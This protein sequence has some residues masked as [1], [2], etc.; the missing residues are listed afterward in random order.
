M[1]KYYTNDGQV[2]FETGEDEPMNKE[3]KVQELNQKIDKLKEELEK[4]QE[5]TY[6]VSYPKD[7]E[8]VYFINPYSN[9]IQHWSFNNWN[10]SIKQLYKLGMLFDT[11]KEAEQFLKEQTLI[12]KIKCWV[13]EQQGDWKPD[14][15]NTN[16]RKYCVDIDRFNKEIIY[17]WHR[18][19]DKLPKLPFFKSEEIARACIDEFVD[20]IIEVFC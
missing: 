11:K 2:Y 20:E 17:D 9:S 10:D 16:Q 8:K 7:G 18:E 13:K 5:E 1:I 14:W 15:N 12:K 3:Q 4:L 19:H 6:E